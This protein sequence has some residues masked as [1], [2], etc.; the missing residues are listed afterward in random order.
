MTPSG[1]SLRRFVE[2]SPS[3]PPPRAPPPPR[4]QVLPPLLLLWLAISVV[5]T[6]VAVPVGTRLKGV[7]ATVVAPQIIALPTLKAIAQAFRAVIRPVEQ[8]LQLKSMN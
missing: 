1:I 4:P 8:E 3:L 6:Q 2:T 7:V 5:A